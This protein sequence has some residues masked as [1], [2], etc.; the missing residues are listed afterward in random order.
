MKTAPWF[1]ASNN[2]VPLGY[3]R[4]GLRLVLPSLLFAYWI[5]RYFQRRREY[6]VRQGGD[7]DP[8]R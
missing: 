7:A 6:L 1:S 3:I 8:I 2:D 4:W 5:Y